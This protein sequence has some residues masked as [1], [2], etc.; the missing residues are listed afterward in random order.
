[1]NPNQQ[2]LANESSWLVMTSA[3]VSGTEDHRSTLRPAL[4]RVFPC[5]PTIGV[6]SQRGLSPCGGVEVNCEG[7]LSYSEKDRIRESEG[8]LSGQRSLCDGDGELG[9]ALRI[10]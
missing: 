5:V 3:M 9:A 7:L 1:M 6:S 4:L 2:E 8:G 10:V